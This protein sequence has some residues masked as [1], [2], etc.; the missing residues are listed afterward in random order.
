MIKT[1]FYDKY[2]DYCK[3]CLTAFL[4][5]TAYAVLNCRP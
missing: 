1:G 4:L 5:H 2:A 3:A